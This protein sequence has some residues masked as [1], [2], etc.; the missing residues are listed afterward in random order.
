MG[1][2]VTLITDFGLADEYVGVMKGVILARAPEARI[3]DI[4]HA[5][6]RHDILRAALFL[7]SAY[8]FFPKGS[9][10]LIVVDP[11]V[12]TNRR[13]VLLKADGHLFLAP[14][15]GIFSLLLEADCFEAA[16]EIQC[17]Q[18]YLVPVS[19]TF[20]GRDILAPVAAHLVGGLEPAEVGPAVLRSSLSNLK[21]ARVIVNQRRNMITGQVVAQDHF[22]NLLTNITEENIRN[23]QAD[24]DI[25][26]VVTIKN[27]TITGIV[28]SYAHRDYGELLAV[29]GS[30]G[31]LEISVNRGNAAAS[32]GAEIG[33]AVT[34]AVGKT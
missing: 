32:L 31:F 20:H 3:V 28:L 14:D 1:R 7:Q 25:P 27:K 16:Y 23:I 29:I 11:G 21:V 5:V 4:S 15:N 13:L 33:E 8:S 26:P 22:G 30:R 9:V 24:K 19:R 2:I 12:G 6:P 17:E 34:V 10:H 18:Y